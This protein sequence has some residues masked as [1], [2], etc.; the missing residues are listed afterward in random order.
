MN[1]RATAT[2]PNEKG[3]EVYGGL[4]GSERAQELRAV[5]SSTTFGAAL[6]RL[7]VDFVFAGIWSRG[8][9][10]PRDRSL[11]TI[12]ALVTQRLS[13]E[14]ENHVRI[15]LNNGLSHAEIEEALIHLLP[16][17]GFPAVAGATA[18]ASRVLEQLAEPVR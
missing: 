13:G 6:A 7:A 12:G 4:L 5:A 3:L 9:L 1:E 14:L 15:A 11:L 16:Y 2:L 10:S 18:V 8:T 17:A